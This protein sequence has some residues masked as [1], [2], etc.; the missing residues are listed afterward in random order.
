MNIRLIPIR[1]DVNIG[2]MGISELPSPAGEALIRLVSTVLGTVLWGRRC[3]KCVILS[4]FLTADCG[5][6]TFEWM[7]I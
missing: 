7:F 1:V 3:M 6:G 4:G 5:K 2:N